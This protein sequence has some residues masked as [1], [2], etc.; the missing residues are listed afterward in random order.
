[1]ESPTQ[2]LERDARL[3]AQRGDVEGAARAWLR[4]LEQRPDNADAH[5]Q[6]GEIFLRQGR[7]AEAQHHFQR[8]ADLA[9][10]QAQTWI[11]LALVHRQ[12][13]NADAEEQALFRALSVDPYDVLALVLR[14]MLFERTARPG[15]AARAYGAAAAIVPDPQRLSPDLRAAVAH[16]IRFCEDHQHSMARHLDDR[17]D[18]VLAGQDSRTSQR[19]RESVDLL[20]GRKRRYES[21]PMR[22]FMPGLPAIPFFDRSYFPWL[23]A[24]EA[25]TDQ[26][27]AEFLAV[28]QSDRPDI[29]PYI[30]YAADQPI[31][32][33]SQLNHN[34]DWSAYHLIQNGMVVDSA[35][36]RCPVTIAAVQATPQPLQEGRT[37][38]AMFSMLKPKT[39]IP[40]HVGASN[41]R[42][43]VHLPLIVPSG[44]HYRV[45]ND[46]RQWREGHAW[47]F[48][49]TIE[50]EAINDSA[51]LRA[52]L[53]FDTW[54]PLLSLEERE[55]ITALNRFL[56][57]FSGAERPTGYD[58]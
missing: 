38:V 53:I 23:E 4:V 31:A 14:G 39:R 40:P 10:M 49:D 41:A 50:H 20:L 2:A 45:G 5:G 24:V 18:R 13:E 52:I 37:P 22:Y 57:E 56:N 42:V 36:E 17:L 43:I 15:E 9:P 11:N 8:A 29:Q 30:Q 51:H 16:G 55:M 33:W 44:C 26:I 46:I 25:Q 58:A 3:L 6:L 48:D 47:V 27:R 34:P 7:L 54:N 21:A 32:Q 1:M 12:A 28:L 35:A 19:F